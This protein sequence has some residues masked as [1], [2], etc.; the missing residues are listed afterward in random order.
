LVSVNNL[1]V[2]NT[3]VGPGVVTIN[4]GS[5]VT[6]S[7]TVSNGAPFAVGDGASAGALVLEA[8]GSGLHLF[9]DGLTVA[10]HSTLQG[11]GAVVGDTSVAGTLSP[12]LPVGTLTFSNNLTLGE[13]A[14]LAI[15][16]SGT[17]SDLVVVGGTAMLGGALTVS[18]FSPEPTN[19]QQI[20][21]LSAGSVDLVLAATNL[22]PGYAMIPASN[23]VVLTYSTN[24]T[25]NTVQQSWEARYGVAADSADADE[26][27]L[28]N[29]DEFEAGFNPTNRDAHP[30]ILDVAISGDYVSITFLGADGDT[31]Y[32]GG[33]SSRLNVVEFASEL[34]SDD[35]IGAGVSNVLGAGAGL[36]TLTNVIFVGEAAGAPSRFYRLRVR[37]P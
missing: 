14:T 17:N 16:V 5:L 4:G 27:G 2:T 29:A 22:P 19:G 7:S 30:R 26:D 33:P 36:G 23:A 8:D 28:S 15:E 34:S 20:T 11:R 10:V 13:A 6:R 21:V 18:A 31:T 3:G 25:A 24:H 12:G 9:A 37:P 32:A 35:F 1:I